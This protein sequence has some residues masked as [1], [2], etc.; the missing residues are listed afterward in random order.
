MRASSRSPDGSSPDELRPKRPSISERVASFVPFT[1]QKKAAAA[2][3]RTTEDAPSTSPETPVP[4]ASSLGDTPSTEGSRERA[5]TRGRSNSMQTELL[6]DQLMKR[7]HE[8]NAAD[9]ITESR[10]NFQAAAQLRNTPQAAL[11]AANMALKLG[12]PGVAR[13]EYLEIQRRVDAGEL[14]PL[15]DAHAQMLKRKLGEAQKAL[16]GSDGAGAPSGDD[17]Y[18]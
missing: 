4:R 6:Y 2:L 10:R 1:K 17:A 5:N 12:Q 16:G 14:T 8:A 11:S 9:K 7:G 15:S 3:R 18:I 13:D